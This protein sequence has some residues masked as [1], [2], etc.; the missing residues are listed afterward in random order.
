MK[1]KTFQSRKN[2]KNWLTEDTK[3]ELKIR[4]NL[5]NLAISSQ[6]PACW[7]NY[8]KMRNKCTKLVKSD[9]NKHYKELFDKA[10]NKN[11]TRK[12]FSIAKNLLGWSKGAEP[13][14]LIAEGKIEASPRKL[15]QIQ[16]QYFRKKVADIKSGLPA[17]RNNPL[18]YL[19]RAFTRWNNSNSLTELNLAGISELELLKIMSSMSNSTY[20]GNDGL[21]A[22]TLKMAIEHLIRPL[23]HIINLSLNTGV[24]ANKWKVAKLIPIYKGKGSSKLEPGS[25]RPVSLLPIVAKIAEKAAQLQIMKH[26][27]SKHLFNENHHAYRAKLST[28]TAIL[29]LSDSIWQGTDMNS[30]TITMAIDETAAFDCVNFKILIDKLK[31]YKFS[32]HS[33]KWMESYLNFRSQ[34]TSIGGHNSEIF[35][36]DGGVPQGSVLGPV[37]FTIY[38]NEM[39]DIINEDETCDDTAHHPGEKLFGKNCTLCGTLPSYVDD[40][41]YVLTNNNRMENQLIVA[42][43]LEK[44]STFLNDNNLVVNQDKTLIAELMTSQK[45]C[46]LKTAPPTLKVKDKKGN[47]KVIISSQKERILGINLQENL[48]WEAQV[49]IGEKALFP[50]VRKVIGAIK[51]IRNLTD[52]KTRLLLANSLVMSRILYLLPIWGGASNKITKE[53]QVIMNLTARYVTN[54]SKRTKGMTLMNRCGWLMADELIEHQSLILMWKLVYLQKPYHVSQKIEVEDD[55]TLSTNRARLKTVNLGWRWRTVK[56]WNHLPDDL[57]KCE[58]LHRFKTKLKEHI[59]TRRVNDPG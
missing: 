21:D 25:Y 35:P 36:V 59:K 57:R 11:D 5:R 53:L 7:N 24:F 30:I 54:L 28:T 31:I 32:E 16:M 17:R 34:F 27:E 52:N 47:W 56:Q 43:K 50:E 42:K 23:N 4:D 39:P 51:H 38:I 9:K 15:A 46:K 33:I 55:K 20:V 58:N 48:S 10:E 19:R 44:I 37:L 12:T 29:Q 22:C 45:R 13:D 41:T 3:T 14:R 26:M 2:Y 18:K 49:N 8:R 6:D 1:I 40:A